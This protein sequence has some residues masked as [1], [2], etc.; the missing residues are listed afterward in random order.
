MSLKIVSRSVLAVVLAAGIASAQLLNSKSLDVIRVEKTGISAGKIDSL[1]Q[2]LAA[3]QFHGKKVNEETMTQ[4]RYAVID[5]LVG[6]ELV[7]LECKKQGI[8]VAQSKV[9]SVT[10]LF[11]K[12]FPSEDA[13]QKELKKS[14]TTMAQFKSKIED[15]LKSEALLEKKVPYPKDPTEK[16]KEAFWELNK[17]KAQINDTIS[18]AR[19]YMSTKGKSKQEIED[20]KEVLKGLAAQVRTK[21]AT[22]AQLAAVYSDD[23]EAKKT[24]G[25]MNKFLAKSKGDAFAK[26]VAKIKV[27]E[28]TDVVVEKDGVSIFMLTEKNDGKYESY[29]HQIDYILRVQAEQD[30]QMQLKAYLDGL[31][32]VYKVQ[33]LDKKYTPPQAIGGAN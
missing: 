20:A 33:Y 1:A 15:Q 8:K 6:Q 7:K 23:P 27:G 5:N 21:K 11:K 18:G 19:I 3:Q 10:K 13:F 29:K 30:R 28:I 32:K 24:G 31:A 2:M 16:Q 22:F 26:A 4:V 17:G 9:D 12:Q 25:V 14:N